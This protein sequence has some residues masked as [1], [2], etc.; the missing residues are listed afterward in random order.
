MDLN[1]RIDRS[2]PP[3]TESA[4]N[5]E[6]GLTRSQLVDPAIVGYEH[7]GVEFTHSDRGSLPSF[8][9]D[10][11]LGRPLPPTFATNGVRD[12]DTLVAIALFLHRDLALQ[13]A[14]PGFVNAVDFVHRLG[15]AG[16]AHIDEPTALFIDGAR[17]IIPEAGSP[18]D[19]GDLV[20]VAVRWIREYVAD[21]SSPFRNMRQHA[22]ARILDQGTEGF[23]FAST[24]GGLSEG[25]LELFRAG[26]LRGILI[27]S[28]GDR[29]AVSITRKSKHVRFDLNSGCRILNHIER[30]MGEPESWELSDDGLWLTHASG[31]LILPSDMLEVLVR[32]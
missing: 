9:E 1:V 28:R 19:I 20:P 14:M 6:T 27:K 29:N 22:G 10:L 5:F 7:H 32:V 3:V 4:I 2:L 12:V 17:N 30:A 31:T 18:R 23:V 25:W 13:P 26:F 21:G 15:A 11:L 8:Y 24:E 16:V